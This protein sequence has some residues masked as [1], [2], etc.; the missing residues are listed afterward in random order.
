GFF[1]RTSA[2][3]TPGIVGFSNAARLGS[4]ASPVF[5]RATSTTPLVR[6]ALQPATGPTDEAVVYFTADATI[7]FDALLDATKLPSANGASLAS[8]PAGSQPL[9]INALPPLGTADVEVSLRL[10]AP[11]AGLRTLRAPELRNLPAGT[12][13]YLRDAQTGAVTDLRQVAGYTFTQA[14]GEPATGRFSLLLTSRRVLA[15]TSNQLSGQVSIY[16][17]PAHSQV[18]VQL[19]ATLSGQPVRA[20]LL[21]SLGQVMVQSSLPG[22]AGAVRTMPLPALATGIYTLRLQTSAGL[23]VKRLAI[24]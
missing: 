21:N 23:V 4:Y 18:A 17:N 1:V 10:Q 14:T 22:S 20:T 2:A 7:G 15:T 13:P 12:V 5:N 11:G 6:L 8:Q 9:A 24:E 3:A 16:P 19:P